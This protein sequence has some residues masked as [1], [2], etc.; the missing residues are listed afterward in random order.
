[1]S[2]LKVSA[3]PQGSYGAL[4]TTHEPTRVY[5]PTPVRQSP[6]DFTASLV[7]RTIQATQRNVNIFL[8]PQ[9]YPS[10]IQR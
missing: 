7:T 1:M 10:S 9:K 4:H 3:M 8:F 6:S 5:E 2:F